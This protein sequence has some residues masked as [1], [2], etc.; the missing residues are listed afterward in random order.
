MEKKYIISRY[1]FFLVSV[2]FNA[3]SIALIT[4]AMLGTSPISSVPLALSLVAPATMGMFT[5]YFNLLFIAL[6]IILMT[7]QELRSKWYELV[8]QIPITLIFG[9]FIDVSTY[10]L[11][12]WLEPTGYF[13]QLLTLILGCA[14]LGFGISMEVKADVAMV[15]GEYLVQ[16]IAKVAHRQFAFVKVCFDCTNVVI[17]CTITL[18]FLGHIDGVREGTVIAALLVGPFSR[19]F[20]PSLNI[21]NKVL[22]ITT[23]H[24]AKEPHH[25]QHHPSLQLFSSLINKIQ[26]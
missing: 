7:R 10:V 25:R 2:L 8:L 3:F 20:T 23:N 17:A 19:L 11:L 22:G 18:I 24:K 13:T 6:D 26:H 15:A 16:N 9:V 12:P 21:F 1:T 4:K 5:I 14:I